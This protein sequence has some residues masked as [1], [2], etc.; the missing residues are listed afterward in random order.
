MFCIIFLSIF[1]IFN[2]ALLEGNILLI[3][4]LPSL[5]FLYLDKS[6]P[7]LFCS[8]KL[9]STSSLRF[10]CVFFPKAVVPKSNLDPEPLPI[11]TSISFAN[12]SIVF[13]FCL[14]PLR[15]FI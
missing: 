8:L 7:V 12:F 6:S 9:D 15:K 2:S 5:V 14:S 11:F 13:I 10:S 4:S 1:F 3:V